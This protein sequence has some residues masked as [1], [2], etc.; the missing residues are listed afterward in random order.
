LRYRD[1]RAILQPDSAV[2]PWGSLFAPQG[3]VEASGLE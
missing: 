2:L 3:L 1:G